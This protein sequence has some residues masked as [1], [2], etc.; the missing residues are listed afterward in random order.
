MSIIE[1]PALRQRIERIEAVLRKHDL[2]EEE[3]QPIKQPDVPSAI[4]HGDY[5]DE[6][7]TGFVHISYT[8]DCP[9]CLQTEEG[10]ERVPSGGPNP[11]RRTT[12]CKKTESAVSL[13]FHRQNKGKLS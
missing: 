6:P 1:L 2:L 7:G 13:F 4:A 12:V 11:F 8:F 3:P 9:L 10:V 5:H